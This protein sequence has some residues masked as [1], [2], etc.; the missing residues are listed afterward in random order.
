MTAH[1]NHLKIYLFKKNMLRFLLIF[2]VSSLSLPISTPAFQN[3]ITTNLAS[4]DKADILS[5][6]LYVKNMS[7]K[8][9][10]IYK[11]LW[12]AKITVSVVD[13]DGL[14][15]PR[16]KIYGFFKGPHKKMLQ[17]TDENGQC[18]FENTTW[19]AK[20]QNFKILKITHPALLYQ[21]AVNKK[22]DSDAGRTQI[23]LSRP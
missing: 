12:K 20:H 22:A 18:I 10:K 7:G 2:I 6:S 1:I 19:L 3:Y 4:E 16:A 5:G 11:R 21:P 8:T 23:I 17:A 13:K 15:V 14:P 9:E